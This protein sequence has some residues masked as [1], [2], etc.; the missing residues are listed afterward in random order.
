MC[1]DRATFNEKKFF[2]NIIIS[3]LI[4]IFLTTNLNALSPS[5]VDENLKI[6]DK[7]FKLM[8]EVKVSKIIDG[9]TIEIESGEKIR[10]IGIDTPELNSDNNSGSEYYGK[11]AK[12]YIKK[13][14]GKDQIVYLEYG[15]EVRDSYDRLLAYIY[16][17][18]G[19]FLNARI[20]REGYSYL[21][22]VP[23]NIKYLNLLEEIAK[24]AREKNKG[25][26]KK[27]VENKDYPQIS[28]KKAE[29]YYGDKVVVEGKV[30]DTHDSGKAVFL[31]F[32]EEYWNTFSAVIFKSDEY[33]FL[34]EPEEYYLNKN[35]KIMGTVEK[36]KGI[37]EII[38]EHPYQI[39]TVR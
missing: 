1:R 38:L 7:Y 23:P 31:N 13:L 26:W 32:A 9:D 11:R 4:I 27:D 35:V 19:T 39:R 36:Y 15:E 18:D 5:V 37:P 17:P 16:L 12:K 34:V 22:T 3:V 21:L 25:L 33:K 8:D 20:L 2:I 24:K 10:L 29:K 30:V 6:D 14:I 28:W